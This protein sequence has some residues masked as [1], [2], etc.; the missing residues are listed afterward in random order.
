MDSKSIFGLLW[1]APAATKQKELRRPGLSQSQN[2]RNS[3]GIGGGGE[4]N[5]MKN[6]PAMPSSVTLLSFRGKRERTQVREREGSAGKK[7]NHNWRFLF[8]DMPHHPSLSH[9]FPPLHPASLPFSEVI[10]SHWIYDYESPSHKLSSTH[11]FHQIRIEHAMGS[12][13]PVDFIVEF[14]T[15]SDWDFPMWS[16]LSKGEWRRELAFSRSGDDKPNLLPGNWNP[17][18]T[19]GI[20]WSQPTLCHSRGDSTISFT[21]TP[22]LSKHKLTLWWPSCKPET[23]YE[24]V[25]EP[26]KLKK[27]KRQ[28]EWVCW[29]NWIRQSTHHEGNGDR[30]WG[31]GE[32][33]PCF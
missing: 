32:W 24:S 27:C 31:I 1:L 22:L 25:V 12:E 3:E 17:P 21:P 6:D 10:G 15:W 16:F 9:S 18:S 28:D 30:G 33:K 5:G 14:L 8:S 2:S 19:G 13:D 4:S 20:P 23:E 29:R 7:E 26:R 11:N